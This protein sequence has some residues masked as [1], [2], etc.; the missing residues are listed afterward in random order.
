MATDVNW[1]SVEQWSRDPSDSELDPFRALAFLG[2]NGFQSPRDEERTQQLIL[3]LLE[4][5]K[6]LSPCSVLLD[7]LVRRLGLFPYLDQAT[8]RST[9]DHIAYEFH[10]PTE[11]PNIVFHRDQAVV[12]RETPVGSKRRI[13]CADQFREVPADRRVDC[14]R[15]TQ[16]YSSVC[17]DDCAY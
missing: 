8:L 1:Q 3:R 9:G 16:R 4:H 14:D 7:A 12:Y 6:L 10:R 5:R 13:E 2:A 11:L 17:T 15:S